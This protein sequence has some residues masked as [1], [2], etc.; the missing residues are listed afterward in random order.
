[1]FFNLTGM[2]I[3]ENTPKMKKEEKENQKKKNS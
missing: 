1:M 3:E 2:A